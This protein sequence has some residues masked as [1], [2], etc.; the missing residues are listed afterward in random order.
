MT[1]QLPLSEVIETAK[2]KLSSVSACRNDSNALKAAVDE[3]DHWLSS[4]KDALSALTPEQ[5]TERQEIKQLIHQLT[6]LE[7]Q[8]R[9]N[10]SLVANMQDYIHTQLDRSTSQQNHYQR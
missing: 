5:V 2:R 3:F 6:Q 10:I 4:H 1:R 7:L 8:A 9:F